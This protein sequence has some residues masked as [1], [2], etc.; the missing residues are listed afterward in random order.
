M[1]DFRTYPCTKRDCPC[2]GTRRV[3]IRETA[4][5][6]VAYHVE[7]YLSAVLGLSAP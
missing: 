5:R 2:G 7:D 3:V 1:S 4:G 6:P